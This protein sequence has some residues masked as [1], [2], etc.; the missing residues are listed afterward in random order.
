[1]SGQSISKSWLIIRRGIRY[2]Y[3]YLGMV[4]AASAL[5][6]FTGFF[7]ILV[8]TSLSKYIQNP[9]V[10]GGAILLTLVTLGQQPQQFSGLLPRCCKKRK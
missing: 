5:W 1:M 3:D 4:I 9:L 6:F 7:P 10:I 8:V 2:S